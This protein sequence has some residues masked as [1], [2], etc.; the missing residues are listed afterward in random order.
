MTKVVI[1]GIGNVLLG[2]DGVGPFAIKMLESQYD[3]SDN[4]EL[5]DLGTPPVDLPVRLGC[6]DAVILVD[7]AKFGGAAGDIRLFRKQEILRKHWCAR[8]DPHAPALRESIVLMALMGLM[9]GE[10][11]LVV[12]QGSRFE[13]G[14]GLS[15]PVRLCIPH[16]IDA[17][18]RE[19]R[20]LDEACIPKAIANPP[21]RISW[22]SLLLRKNER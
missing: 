12:M 17:V 22:A 8:L 7:S 20:R 15:T 1:A 21:P 2:D 13:P 11:L 19:L 6:A 14:S 16:I 3:F 18:R 4:V 10:L 9:P 5:A